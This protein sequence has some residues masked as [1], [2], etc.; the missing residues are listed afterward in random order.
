VAAFLQLAD[1]KHGKVQLGE[2]ADDA[3]LAQ[4]VFP[5]QAMEKLAY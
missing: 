4:V 5:S 2:A 3:P 1:E